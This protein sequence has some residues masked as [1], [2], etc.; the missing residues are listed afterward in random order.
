MNKKSILVRL[1][2]I[3]LLT[4]V[5]VILNRFGTIMT[6]EIK[7]G[8]SFVP[9]MLCGMLFPLVAIFIN[10]YMWKSKNKESAD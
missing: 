7:I 9:I 2:V 1:S 6:A 5:T 4:A 10:L 8:F 3:A